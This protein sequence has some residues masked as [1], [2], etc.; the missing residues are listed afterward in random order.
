MKNPIIVS[1]IILVSLCVVVLGYL[2]FKSSTEIDF[3]LEANVEALNQN[4]NNTDSLVGENNDSIITAKQQALL[5]NENLS[6]EI[7]Y[8]YY[9]ITGSFSKK[10]NAE[11][12][13]TLLAEKGFLPKIIRSDF[14]HYKVSIFSSSDKSVALDSLANIKSQE[15]FRSA[16]L[17][18]R[19]K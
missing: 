8:R 3:I 17:L 1:I 5:Y 19:R 4:L 11:R 10:E 16:W 7:T 6:H 18:K 12:Q 14:E 15:E 9:I 13:K 2:Y